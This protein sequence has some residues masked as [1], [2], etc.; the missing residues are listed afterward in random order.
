MEIEKRFYPIS[1]LRASGKSIVGKIPY[2]SRSENLGGFF[3][4]LKP[5][6]FSES[7]R[8]GA[9]IMS[10]WNHD[11]G[12]V[13]GS[14]S[15]NTLKIEDRADALYFTIFPPENSWGKDALASIARGDVSGASFAFSDV[16][17]EW[18]LDNNTKLRTIV[19]AKLHEISPTSIPAY[20]KTEASVRSRGVTMDSTEGKIREELRRHVD[21]AE[22][23]VEKA[24]SENRSLST[25]EN[26]E[27]V[28]RMLSFDACM[29]K[30]GGLGIRDLKYWRDSGLEGVSR[31]LHEPLKPPILPMP[32]NYDKADRAE[33]RAMRNFRSF[34][35]G[36]IRGGNLQAD[37]D[38]VGG[39]TVPQEFYKQ[40]IEEKKRRTPIRGLARVITLTSGDSLSVPRLADRVKNPSWTSELSIGARDDEND[41]EKVAFHCHPL[42]VYVKV[43]MDL[44]E[45]S[46]VDIASFVKDQLAYR[47]STVEESS[48]LVGDGA[49]KPLGVF[50]ASDSGIS[51]SRDC[52]TGNTTT[53]QKADNLISTQHMLEPQ[54]WPNSTW[55][56]HTDVLK[57]VRQ[58]KLGDGSYI[59]SPG[60][61]SGMPN[62]ILDRP[63]ILSMYAPST[64]T[65]GQY[66]AIIGDWSAFWIVESIRMKIS[67]LDQL[68]AE[69]NMVAY[70]GRQRLDANAVDESAFARCKLA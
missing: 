52:S 27:F 66:T 58:L 62:T 46:G 60:I 8:S 10:F 67:V 29:D 35:R 20:S 36:E 37:L 21:A 70:V 69:Q 42:A 47:F 32:M 57:Q 53:E 65:S 63:Y 2:N 34:L 55:V 39:F 24:K 31:W 50:V 25:D 22:Q 38:L 59:W 14:T 26:N 23:I 48:F 49:G 56:M 28:N 64:M 30:L 40:V 33:S 15:A 61:S 44:L 19:S 43:S 13:L 12:M 7:I 54:Y 16:R 1:E 9:K 41:F 51:T 3:E 68:Y 4:V 45:V 18:S 5:H 11:S 6:C 17:D